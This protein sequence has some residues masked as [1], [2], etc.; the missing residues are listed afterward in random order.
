MAFL[1]IFLLVLY[2]F[3]YPVTIQPVTRILSDSG[4]S[5]RGV[6]SIG[7]PY[8]SYLSLF[9]FDTHETI[10]RNNPGNQAYNERYMNDTQFGIVNQFKIAGQPFSLPFQFNPYYVGWSVCPDCFLSIGMGVGS[11]L[12]N[13]YANISYG[14]FGITF[15]EF[16]TYSNHAHDNS[17]LCNIPSASIC[18]VY[19]TVSIIQPDGTSAIAPSSANGTLLQIG[20]GL[21]PVTYLPTDIYW[22]IRGTL[23]P[24]GD[25][26]SKWPEVNFCDVVTGK[27]IYLDRKTILM[28]FRS[29]AE[30]TIAPWNNTSILLGTSIAVSNQFYFFSRQSRMGTYHHPFVLGM[31]SVNLLVAL[32]EAVIFLFVGTTSLN[33]NVN[34]IKPRLFS[35]VRI[36]FDVIALLLML[37]L[38]TNEE[39]I[40]N[41]I[42]ETPAMLAFIILS[43]IILLILWLCGNF[44]GMISVAR[45][46]VLTVHERMIQAGRA[47]MRNFTIYCGVSFVIFLS[48]LEFYP[49]GTVEL[50]EFASMVIYSV[51]TS[52]FAHNMLFFAFRIWNIEWALYFALAA[53]LFIATNV[54]SILFFITPYVTQNLVGNSAW[55]NGIMAVSA[56]VVLV[57]TF[58]L[59]V[60]S[61]MPYLHY[62]NSGAIPRF[63]EKKKQKKN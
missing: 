27:C 19:V 28:V 60:V 50:F 15:D 49:G 4:A 16:S 32:V 3:W 8:Y 33:I 18:D 43:Y 1:Q 51:L 10:Y 34:P 35:K 61:L 58:V 30:S 29:Y 55:A 48:S 7:Q 12:W 62:I 47:L 37:P 56:F 57:M 26:Q 23:T 38:L 17:M 63:D 59:C 40:N 9:Q 22:A 53:L 5:F 2:Q 39:F 36:V 25:D 45:Q 6:V 24:S 52:V 46:D 11:P 54:V 14:Q 44:T 41:A 20:F 31:E 13:T 42:N 21:D